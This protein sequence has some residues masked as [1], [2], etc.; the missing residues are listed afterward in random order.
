MLACWLTQFCFPWEVWK[1]NPSARKYERTLKRFGEAFQLSH[2][3][4]E[5]LLQMRMIR[6]SCS[7]TSESHLLSH[8][9]NYCTFASLLLMPQSASGEKKKM[10]LEF[11][12]WHMGNEFVK[13]AIDGRVWV[14]F[15]ALGE[16]KEIHFTFLTKLRV[17][18]LAP[19]RSMSSNPAAALGKC[20]ESWAA[21]IHGGY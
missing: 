3:L 20:I 14:S 2:Y 10:H 7:R 15:L 12:T 11:K 21:I 8:Y 16:L 6:P 4:D 18:M 9:S 1:L 5:I 13:S 19:C 17:M